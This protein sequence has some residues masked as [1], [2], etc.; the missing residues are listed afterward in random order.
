MTDIT[1]AIEI[2]QDDKYRV[3][4]SA[5]IQSFNYEIRLYPPD[6]E[7]GFKDGHVIGYGDG[8][9]SQWIGTGAEIE[10]ALV[11]VCVTHGGNTANSVSDIIVQL[12]LERSPGVVE[13]LHTWTIHKG[14]ASGEFKCMTLQ[15]K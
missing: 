11:Q 15:F 7:G 14:L 10:G 9:H 12:D 8:A 6:G 4:V 2:D 1:Q 3:S 13:H 5:H